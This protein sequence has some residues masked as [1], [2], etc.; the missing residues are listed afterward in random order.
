MLDKQTIPNVALEEMNAVHHEEVDLINALLAQLD[1]V[2]DGAQPAEML[3]APLQHLLKHLREHFAGE[4]RRMLEAAFP[5]YPMHKAE[6]DR[7]FAQAR[8]VHEAWLDSR[9]VQALADYLGRT[10]PG[11]MMQHIATMDAVTAR[12]LVS[13]L[14]PGTRAAS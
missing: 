13:R 11:W 12:F 9:D 14:P 7:V 4:E 5:P 2:G 6:H 8:S 1:A 10:L 3:D